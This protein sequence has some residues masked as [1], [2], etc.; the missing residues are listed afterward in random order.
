LNLDVVLPAAIALIGLPGTGKSTVGRQ[1]ARQLDLQFVDTDHLIEQ[2]IGCSISNYFEQHGEA[3]F[4]KIE[5][6]VIDEVTARVE[7]S[8]IA[9]GGGVVLHP[10]NREH[11]HTR[12]T[13]VYLRAS[14]EELARRMRNDQRRPLLQGGDVL[15]K[16]RNLLAQRDPLYRQTAHYVIEAQR[17]SVH[18]MTNMVLM[19]LELAGVVKPAA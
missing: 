2:R 11:L 16:M 18:S 14:A 3:A 7:P 8:V 9:T 15:T 12:A 1:V 4:R 17:P 10:D 5:A 13:V 19:Q 6:Q